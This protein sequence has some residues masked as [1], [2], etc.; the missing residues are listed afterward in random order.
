L[1]TKHHSQWDQILPQE[2]FSYNDSPNKSSGKSPFQIVYGIHPRGISELITLGHDEFRSAG[3][4]YFS[5]EM[6]K[7]HDQINGQLHDSSQKYKRHIDQRKREDH[8]K[9]QDQFLALLT[10]ERFPRGICNKLKMKKIGPC[11]ILRKFATNAYEIELPKNVGISPIFNVVDLY[12][13][14]MDDTRGLGDQK[15]IQWEK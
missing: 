5:A 4:E 12:P 14:R 9:V 8:F 15:D 1:V 6:H 2:K 3:A 7:L 10:K 13:Y 11:R